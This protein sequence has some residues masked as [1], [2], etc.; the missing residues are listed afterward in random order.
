MKKLFVVIIGL[1]LLSSVFAQEA[2]RP[3][4]YL[5]L[6]GHFPFGE[7]ASGSYD[8]ADG[9]ES[10]EKEG[11]FSPAPG[12]TLG[13]EVPISAYIAIRP[14]ASVYSFNGT[15]YVALIDRPKM[16]LYEVRLGVDLIYYMSTIYSSGVYVIGTF[17]DNIEKLQ[18]DRILFK[19]RFNS[20]RLTAGVG[21]GYTF[22]EDQSMSLE[23]VISKS[24]SGV[25]PARPDFPELTAVR[26]SFGMKF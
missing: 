16:K 12:F 20:T 21:M 18:V 17:G 25:P 10:Y 1:S 14:T 8:I 26:V 3:T 7:F 4:L 13:I 23:A 22:G 24:V 15:H 2:K 19:E 6:D 11:T 5:G 9:A